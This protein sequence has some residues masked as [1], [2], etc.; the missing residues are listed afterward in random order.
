MTVAN[1][2]NN[3]VPAK[4]GV[5]NTDGVTIKKLYA[6]PSTHIIDTNIEVGGSDLGNNDA[7]RD[8][9]GEPVMLA[10]SSSDGIT[11]VP[12]YIDSSN[13]LLIKST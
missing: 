4:I 13:C 8:D 12:L 11:P 1:K 7:I 10:V 2:D 6:D 3:R 9:N 5:L